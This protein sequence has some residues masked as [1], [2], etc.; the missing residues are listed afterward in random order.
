M[1]GTAAHI[2]AA[3]PGGPRGTG[4]LNAGQR[5]DPLNGIWL[6][7][8]CARLVDTNAGDAYPASLLRSW[9]DLH[10]ARVRMEH[11]GVARPFGW[12]HSIEIM[13]DVWLE[14]PTTVRFSRC[15][16]FLGT[17]GIGKSHFISLL[18]G[19]AAPSHIMERVARPASR[20]HAA[21]TWYDPQPRRAEFKA[22]GDRLHFFADG[23]EVPFV[24]SPYQVVRVPRW[25]GDF[26]ADVHDLAKDL[27]LDHWV[28]RK[29]ISD[30]PEIV[31]GAVKR[32]RIVDDRIRADFVLGSGL[33]TDDG[34]RRLHPLVGLEVL[35]ALAETYARAHPTLLLLDPFLNGLDWGGY[36]QATALLGSPA[37]G[38]QTV[39]VSTDHRGNHPLGPEWTVTRIVCDETER[40]G[41]RRW[42]RLVQDDEEP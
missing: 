41:H 19:L 25:R 37:R 42:A 30:L 26:P 14:E 36:H 39:A 34:D 32:T 18:S 21:L 16:I 5:S 28:M 11:G 29:V 10:E 40:M 22:E 1:T 4:G 20:V 33:E 9:R 31:G 6:C 23:Q 15:N 35:V 3:A 17:N 8:R 27:G 24:A 12:I 38:F 2:Y 7:A 13:E